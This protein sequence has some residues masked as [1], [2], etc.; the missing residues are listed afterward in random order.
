MADAAILK[1]HICFKCKL[2]CDKNTNVICCSKC[3]NWY[4]KSCQ[5]SNGPISKAN[6]KYCDLCLSK[7]N[8]H[9]CCKKF[10]PRSLRVNCINCSNS[11]CSTCV[12]KTEK[13]I[14]F[15]L[16]PEN[17]FFVMIV[18]PIFHV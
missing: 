11:F 6:K 10:F 9:A 14:K 16:C 13:N 3:F 15:Y 18:M 4:H 5:N 1:N 12:A 8:C 7:T 2:G 17:D